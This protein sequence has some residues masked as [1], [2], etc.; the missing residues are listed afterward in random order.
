MVS[1]VCLSISLL[2]TMHDIWRDVLNFTNCGTHYF[3]RTEPQ[4]P[5]NLQVI[6]FKTWCHVV[7][8]LYSLVKLAVRY[9]LL[10]RL[11][12]SS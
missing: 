6:L 8:H 12:A 1:A 9:R 2:E 10:L 11:T 3:A 4:G 7:I 5:K